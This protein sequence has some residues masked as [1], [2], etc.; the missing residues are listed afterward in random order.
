M[1][2]VTTAVGAA[3]EGAPGAGDGWGA[4]VGGTG[5]P[6]KGRGLGVPPVEAHAMV[7][8]AIRAN[9]TGREGINSAI[10]KRVTPFVTWFLRPLS[11]DTPARVRASWWRIWSKRSS[12][13]P[14]TSL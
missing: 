4:A 3:I 13:T 9:K 14:R 7:P 8:A 11:L 6:G 5:A 1:A 2:V 12:S 10:V